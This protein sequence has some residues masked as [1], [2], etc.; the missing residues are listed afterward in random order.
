[1]Q[2]NCSSAKSIRNAIALLAPQ[3]IAGTAAPQPRVLP[4]LTHATRRGLQENL[5]P[6]LWETLAWAALAL[7]SLSAIVISLAAQ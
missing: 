4:N 7:C 1:M 5:R 2:M 6:E 3:R